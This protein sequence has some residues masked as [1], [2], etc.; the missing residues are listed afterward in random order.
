MKIDLLPSVAAAQKPQGKGAPAAPAPGPKPTGSGETATPASGPG[1]SAESTAFRAAAI[2]DDATPEAFKNFGDAVSQLAR[3]M[4]DLSTGTD[5]P[6]EGDGTGETGGT[7]GETGGTTTETGGTT[8]ETGGTTTET[9]G[10]TE[11]TGGT[12]T[13]TSGTTTE[14]G[15]TTG[16]LVDGGAPLIVP[17]TED[18]LIDALL[19]PGEGEDEG[20]GEDG[21]EPTA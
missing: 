19:D 13:Q 14:T 11:E 5:E 8:T 9:S 15:G 4:I 1:K 6:T 17:T 20:E 7:T 12:T 10:T 18:T 16:G 2:Y 21:S 3:N